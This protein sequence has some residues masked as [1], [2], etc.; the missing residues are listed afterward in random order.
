MRLSSGI[1]AFI[2]R[3]R[4][5][6]LDYQRGNLCLNAFCRLVGDLP[7]NAVSGQDVLAFLDA[8]QVCAK[9]WIGKHSV[10]RHFFE[11]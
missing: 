8:S 4:A 3:R 2:A 6:G 10:L 1:E 7:L 11:F 9:T 5:E